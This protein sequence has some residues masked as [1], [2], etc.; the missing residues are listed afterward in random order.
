MGGGDKGSIEIIA[1]VEGILDAL[2]IVVVI[3]AAAGAK[4]AR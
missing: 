4:G 1:V 2:E 3:S